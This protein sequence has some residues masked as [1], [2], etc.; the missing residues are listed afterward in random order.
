MPIE[1]CLILR[2][3]IKPKNIVLTIDTLVQSD[4]Y[5]NYFYF[6]FF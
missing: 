3:F 2:N 1:F 6:A 4:F 5:L